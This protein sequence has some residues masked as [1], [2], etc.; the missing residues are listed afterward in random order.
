LQ[1]YCLHSH[2]RFSTRHFSWY[3][4]DLSQRISDSEWHGIFLTLLV[5]S[6]PYTRI[7][8]WKVLA[9][10]QD[11]HG[12]VVESKDTVYLLRDDEMTT[13]GFPLG[14]SVLV[15]FSLSGSCFPTPSNPLPT[16]RTDHFPSHCVQMSVGRCARAGGSPGRFGCPTSTNRCQPQNPNSNSN[17]RITTIPL[18]PRIKKPRFIA[19]NSKRAPKEHQKAPSAVPAAQTQN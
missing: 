17:C 3:F 9:G 2:S 13:P 16:S 4:T 7:C 18:L 6:T 10:T 11:N 12:D 14:M 15:G 19:L 8:L 1:Y 5:S